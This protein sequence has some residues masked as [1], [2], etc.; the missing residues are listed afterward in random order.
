MATGEVSPDTSERPP[1]V[2]S[3]AAAA[4][5]ILFVLTAYLPSLPG[6]FLNYDDDWLLLRNPMLRAPWHRAAAWVFTDLR[7]STRMFLGAEYLP[8][9]DVFVW[10]EAQLV[11]VRAL[12]MR[13]VSLG[14]YA[15][16]VLLARRWF[17][18]ALGAGLVGELA[19]WLFALHAAHVE[20]AAWLAG[21]KDLLALVFVLSALL[22][23][24]HPSPRRAWLAPCF[25]IL[26]MLSKS[27][28]VVAAPLMLLDDERARRRP[29]WAVLAT[30]TAVS[31]AAMAV[32]V[33]VGRVVHMV[34]PPL[35]GGRVAAFATMGP[36]WW[37]YLAH[38]F[39]PVGL[40]IYYEV[41]RRGP[42]D[43][44]A[45]A[46]WAGL[47]A[48]LA[49]A[50]VAWRRGARGPLRLI[51]LAAVSMGPMS[52]VL[53]PLQNVMADRYLLLAVAAPCIAVAWCVGRLRGA[54]A[55]RVAAAVLVAG[56]W[57]TTASRAAVFGDS[58]SLWADALAKSS[59]DPR[60]PFQLGNALSA[61]G[62]ARGAERAWRIAWARTGPEGPACVALNNLSRLLAGEGRQAEAIALLRDGISRCPDDP[63][64]LNNLA[65]LLAR[66]GADVEARARYE[67]L[68][69]RFPGYTVGRQNYERRYGPR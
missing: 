20:S 42:G 11:G 58:V 61:T 55:R 32:H 52:Q 6:E 13:A 1:Q 4:L 27:M 54:R 37:R 12:P 21:Q 45:W 59:V 36:V 31:L 7:E 66:A 49:A 33:R 30:T 26:A 44:V 47:F 10:V 57:V 68:V 19:A 29:R 9:R 64:A 43:P 40:S 60:P 14:L 63:K 56:A 3:R 2:P 34:Q 5:L 65:E 22:A 67:D 16:S 23:Y 69:R 48:L 18:R 39:A 38:A 15:A 25:V 53:V 51:V 35:G 50:V 62:D 17:H 8:V 41:P 28:S 46:A 24:G